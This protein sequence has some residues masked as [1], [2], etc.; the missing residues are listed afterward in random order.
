MREAEE[1][2]L[3]GKVS[4]QDPEPSGAEKEPRREGRS[5]DP[6]PQIEFI[7]PALPSSWSADKGGM[8]ARSKAR[9][10]GRELERADR[11]QPHLF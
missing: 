4:L 2:A 9:L 7:Y 8:I 1:A 5:E 11:W 10:A 6:A 3:P